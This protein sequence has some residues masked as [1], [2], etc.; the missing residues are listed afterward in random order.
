MFVIMHQLLL[1][2]TVRRL[3]IGY[4]ESDIM[5]FFFHM[6]SLI[7][8]KPQ[9][10][11]KQG[12]NITVSLGKFGYTADSLMREVAQPCSSMVK[13]CFWMGR[14]MPCD[15]LIFVSKSE[16]G[17]CCSFNRYLNK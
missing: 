8:P 2:S 7:E 17:Y 16:K 10:W 11:P 9:E 13:Q 15:E 14:S 6:K 3:Q 5:E 1:F 4:N 12:H